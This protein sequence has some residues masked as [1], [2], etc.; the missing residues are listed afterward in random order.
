MGTGEAPVLDQQGEAD[1]LQNGACTGCA[2][3]GEAPAL[4]P[5]ERSSHLT[6]KVSPCAPY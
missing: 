1:S 5:N 4:D 2:A 3:Q 6:E